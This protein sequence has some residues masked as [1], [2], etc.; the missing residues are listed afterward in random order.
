VR[1]SCGR[2][3]REQ[4]PG[5]RQPGLSHHTC[6]QW[7]TIISGRSCID[8]LFS[9]ADRLPCPVVLLS[10]GLSA[11]GSPEYAEYFA[12]LARFC[13]RGVSVVSLSSR[14]EETSFCAQHGL[15]RP[16]I[17]PNGVVLAEWD[18][19]PR[20]VRARWRIGG[21]P[22]VIS[23]SNHSTVKN[24]GAFWR[25]LDFL[26]LHCPQVHG[27]IIG[28]PYV[29]DRRLA[30][31]LRVKGGCWYACCARSVWQRNVSMHTDVPRP[32]V[33][34]AVQEADLLLVTSHREA[35]PLI[36][37]E[38][39]AAGTPW[40]S[41]S[42]GAVADCAGGVVVD[43]LAEMERVAAE[44]LS[45]PDEAR[46]LATAGRAAVV[47][48]HAWPKIAAQHTALYASILTTIVDAAR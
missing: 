29:A 30:R 32:D 40:I 14:L 48:N 11:Y 5:G 24:H 4:D 31:A 45:R 39:M 36:L 15:P 37:L 41:L 38:C 26:R 44:L 43:S 3:D 46:K 12:T 7:T 33:V 16:T 28:R 2:A 9:I 6:A 47:G 22:W 25:I 8:S 27:S 35:A 19:R 20:N 1:S 18:Q 13:Q 21:V 42:L 10:H 23:V 34:S 17:I